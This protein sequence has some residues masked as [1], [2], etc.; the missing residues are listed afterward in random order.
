MRRLLFVLL[1]V[2]LAACGSAPRRDLD[3]DRLHASLEAL[4]ADPD[5]AR[6]ALAERALAEAAV[7]RLDA[8]SINAAEHAQLAYVAERRVDIAYVAAQ[9][10]REAARLV[11]LQ[12]EHAQL[13]LA[14]SRRETE[15]V[16]AELDR[17][18]QRELLRL[19]AAERAQAAAPP[20]TPLSQPAPQ[21]VDEAT[22]A[23]AATAVVQAAPPAVVAESTLAQ[24]L[25]RLEP[26]AGSDG[27]QITL[28]DLVFEPGTSVFVAEAA[29]GLS[30]IAAW[31]GTVPAATIR[32]EGHT[33]ATGSP[34][35][36]RSLSLRRAETVRDALVAR[37]VAA[38]RISVSGEGGAQPVA[39]N[40]D[41]AGR[42]LNRR[43]V[44]R[45]E[46]N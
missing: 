25:T 5:L 34:E 14:A 43:V 35:A 10:E 36:N 17:E 28:E 33:D 12:Q 37:G 8:S 7:R 40:D 46:V 45:L 19:E 27:R 32:I 23:V 3:F 11:Q 16:R 30:R 2:A 1:S 39:S 6:H 21:L 29:A 31:V 42:A 13:L 20:A 24:R 15:A 9:T 4:A 22:P 26:D 38:T 44:V 41:A 18:R